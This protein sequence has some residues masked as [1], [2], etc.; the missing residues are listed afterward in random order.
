MRRIFAVLS[1]LTLLP[2]PASANGFGWLRRA[3][4][5]APVVYYYTP[6]PVYVVPVYEVVPARPVFVS[7]PQTVPTLAPIE[8]APPSADPFLPP[9]QGPSVGEARGTSLKPI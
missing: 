8:I 2:A 9:R 6:T 4:E 5:P 7:A 3:R 1:L